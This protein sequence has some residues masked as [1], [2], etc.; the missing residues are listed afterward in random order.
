MSINVQKKTQLIENTKYHHE[1]IK[2]L[3]EFHLQSIGDNWEDFLVRNHFEQK[4]H[5]Q[6]SGSKTLRGRKRKIETIIEQDSQHQ[7]E[8]LEY[9]ILIVEILQKMNRES[10]RRKKASKET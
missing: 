3:I 4:T 7:Q 6:S 1:L 5:E 10:L 9:D 2:I 8:L